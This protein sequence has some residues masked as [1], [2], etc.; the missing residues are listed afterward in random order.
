MARAGRDGS[1]AVVSANMAPASRTASMQHVKTVAVALE[2]EARPI[3]VSCD[4]LV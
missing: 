1:G 2:G 4:R 3:T